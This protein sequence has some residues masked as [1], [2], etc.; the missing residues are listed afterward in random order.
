MVDAA[1]A[2]AP[3][4]P[5][6]DT[7]AA[8]AELAARLKG[9]EWELVLQMKLQAGSIYQYRSRVDGRVTYVKRRKKQDWAIAWYFDPQVTPYDTLENLAAAVIAFDAPEGAPGDD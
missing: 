2:A 6:A 5:T 3:A 4:P 9:G 8:A 7:A 1:S